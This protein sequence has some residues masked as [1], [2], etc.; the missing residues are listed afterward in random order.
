MLSMESFQNRLRQNRLSQV[1]QDFGCYGSN[2]IYYA[3]TGHL[4]QAKVHLARKKLKAFPRNALGRF[5]RVVFSL[6]NKLQGL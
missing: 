6:M 5:R 3:E 4:D 1:P 2:S